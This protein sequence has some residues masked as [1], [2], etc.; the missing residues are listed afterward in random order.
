[1]FE[2]LPITAI[3]ALIATVANPVLAHNNFP[4]LL[5]PQQRSETIPTSTTQSIQVNKIEVVG[6]KIFSSERINTIV[7]PLQGKAVSFAQLQEVANQ[8]TQLYHNHGY[9][10]FKAI[11]QKQDLYD[12]IIEIHII[13]NSHLC[14]GNT[15]NCST[16]RLMLQQ[17]V[18]AK[19][20]K[21]A[22]G[23]VDKLIEAIPQEAS[24]LREYKT[25]LQKYLTQ[26][27]TSTIQNSPL[28]QTVVPTLDFDNP[29]ETQNLAQTDN[30]MVGRVVNGKFVLGKI[31]ANGKFETLL[32]KTQAGVRLTRISMVEAS[33]PESQEIDL[34]PYDG[35]VISV[36]GFDGG[37][38]IYSAN[39]IKVFGKRPEL[40]DLKTMCS[41]QN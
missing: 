11:I 8:T 7:E 1:M 4:V 2:Y 40:I 22:I 33:S 9:T 3:A 21:R 38:I 34:H 5:L 16:L 14:N 19:N 36:V 32:Q 39:I 28:A 30:C 24:Q 27:P 18:E 20:W 37:G 25:Q 12:G 10:N 13:E 41:N 17:A 23:I 6:N 35:K 26:T 29:L 31:A 15:Y